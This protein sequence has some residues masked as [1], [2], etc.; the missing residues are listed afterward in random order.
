MLTFERQPS[1]DP[2]HKR[3]VKYWIITI[4]FSH[5]NKMEFRA[6]SISEISDITGIPLQTLKKLIYE[7]NTYKTKRY[8]EFIKYVECKPVF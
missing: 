2:K 7:K 8:T 6:R 1:K 5:V 3:I 4:Q